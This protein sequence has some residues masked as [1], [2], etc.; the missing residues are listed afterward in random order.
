M[1]GTVYLSVTV[2]TSFVVCENIEPGHG[3]MATDNIDVA[4]L[5]QMMGAL[6]Q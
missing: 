6:S 3:Q 5:A 1:I 2:H 4:L